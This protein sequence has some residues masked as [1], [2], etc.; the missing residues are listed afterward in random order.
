MKWGIRRYQNPDGS[1]TSAGKRRYGISLNEDAKRLITRDTN[2]AKRME[3]LDQRFERDMK[4][5]KSPDDYFGEDGK[6]TK[7]G[8]AAMRK[9]GRVW[10]KYQRKED[11]LYDAEEKE[12]HKL[13]KRVFLSRDVKDEV[14]KAKELSKRVDSFYEDN[15]GPKSQAYKQALSEYKKKN[16]DLHDAE[17]G[18]DHYEWQSGNK[19]YD[20]AYKKC[21]IELKSLEKEYHD[22]ATSIGKKIMGDYF[23]QY[24]DDTMF[25]VNQYIYHR[26]KP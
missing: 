9:E 26:Y 11:I 16:K 5:I 10:K 17:Y 1:Y 14:R 2:S 21:K 13:E 24:K 15:M 20:A 12:L 3:E 6:L 7:E 4:K 8:R 22:Q 25:E 19:A 23:E 18:F